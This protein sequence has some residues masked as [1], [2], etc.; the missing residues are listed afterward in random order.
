MMKFA[1]ITLVRLLKFQNQEENTGMVI[2]VRS[3]NI[4]NEFQIKKIREELGLSQA[5]LGNLLGVSD[6]TFNRWENSLIE[7]ER[8]NVKKIKML[9]KIFELV[10]EDTIDKDYFKLLSKGEYTI[11][12][13]YMKL[14]QEGFIDHDRE[15]DPEFLFKMDNSTSE[16]K[17]VSKFA[18]FPTNLIKQINGDTE[19]KRVRELIKRYPETVNV[20]DSRG[21]SALMEA[22]ERGYIKIAKIL[23]EAGANVNYAR[24]NDTD[25]ITVKFM[26]KHTQKNWKEWGD[27]ALHS[28][29]FKAKPAHGIST[30]QR[31]KM[32]QLLLEHGA[33]PNAI[34]CFGGT[35]LTI[36]V[37]AGH[38]VD[39]IR[40]LIDFNADLDYQNDIEQS[41]TALH[42]AIAEERFEQLNYLLKAGAK[43]NLRDKNGRTPLE[44]ARKLNSPAIKSLE[45]F[46]DSNS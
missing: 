40:R 12:L 36:A 15:D 46:S 30:E 32:T 7:P 4:K 19:S 23:L 27:T 14:T 2:V 17:T 31:I 1:K 43:T 10:V 28:A 29:L 25:A 20:A 16:R 11:E 37:D 6:A 13:I 9:R 26:S 21:S 44:Y 38:P 18:L 42:I 5:E 22:A 34:G 3:D 8:R 41:M 39:L 35:P 33:D 45:A 24:K